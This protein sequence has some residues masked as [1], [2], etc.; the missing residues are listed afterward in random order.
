MPLPLL[1]SSGL[2]E[3]QRRMYASETTEN[4]RWV[5]KFGQPSSYTLTPTD[6]C[7][8][9]LQAEL[10]DI[11]QFAEVAHGKLSPTF[12]WSNLEHLS[13]TDFPLNEYHALSGSLLISAFRGT[14]AELQGY[15]AY[16]PQTNQLVIAFSGTSSVSQTSRNID[17]RFNHPRG[18]RCGVHSGFWKLYQGVRSQ[19]LEGLTRGLASHSVDEV[20]L[21][22]HSLG[23]AMCYLLALDIMG[24]DEWKPGSESI[25]KLPLK[26][27][28]FG[29]PRVGN[30]ALVQQWRT[31]VADRIS[32]GFRVIEYSVRGYN[33]GQRHKSLSDCDTNEAYLRRTLNSPVQ[34]RLSSSG[35]DAFIFRTRLSIP[36]P[37]CRGRVFNFQ[38][39]FRRQ[40]FKGALF[41]SSPRR[42]QLL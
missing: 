18:N 28:V 2:S 8:A 24:G 13:Q 36:Y 41:G 20:V 22:G 1:T 32:R 26:L 11:G 19:A 37:C 9:D 35:R 6:L 3:P 40:I 16:R 27:V 29:S 5:A 30:S 38:H 12:I 42:S 17:V 33:D 14:V 15:I 21:T 4:F 10:A 31:I 25:T 34:F 39:Q 7:D 23:S